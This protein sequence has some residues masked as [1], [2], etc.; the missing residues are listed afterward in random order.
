M[1]LSNMFGVFPDHVP[2]SLSKLWVVKYPDLV[3]KQ[4]L[5]HPFVVAPAGQCALEY[6]AVIT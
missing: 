3:Y 4:K 6:D 5:C 1:L 2:E